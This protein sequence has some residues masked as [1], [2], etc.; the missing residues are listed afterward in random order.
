VIWFAYGWYIGYRAWKYKAWTERHYM[1][2]KIYVRVYKRV[3]YQWGYS[4]YC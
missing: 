2:Y 3:K 1:V 4:R